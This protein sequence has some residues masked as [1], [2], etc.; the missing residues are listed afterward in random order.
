MGHYLIAYLA[1]DFN[2]LSRLDVVAGISWQNSWV[3]FLALADGVGVC[4]LGA[5]LP[6]IRLAGLEPLLAIKEE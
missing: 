4:L 6:V 2:L 1:A 5:L 3:S